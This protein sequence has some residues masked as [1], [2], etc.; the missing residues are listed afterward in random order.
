M[1]SSIHPS[2]RVMMHGHAGGGNG[3]RGWK[4][5]AVEFLKQDNLAVKGLT[6]LMGRL[7][8][9]RNALR[10]LAGRDTFES[11]SAAERGYLRSVEAMNRNLV[12]LSWR[13]RPHL[14]VV[15]GF[16]GMH[17]EGPRH[18]TPIKLGVVIAGIDAVAVDTV[19][20]AVM[21]FDPRAIGYL[22]YAGLAGLGVADLEA[23]HVVGDPIASVR[24]RFVPH[25]NH[26]VQ[27]Y[28][29]R[30][31]ASA[32]EPLRGPHFTKMSERSAAR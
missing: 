22:H 12:T 31:A 7:K 11:L 4:R 14:S 21:G 20:A 9:G 26:A 1:L 30:L 16:V 5:W 15:D 23:I 32:Q 13:T 8:N 28:W 3:Y 6:R 27:K 29:P 10:A 24:R 17:R 19:A 2:D 25:S 18:G